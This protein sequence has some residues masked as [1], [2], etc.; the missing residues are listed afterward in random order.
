MSYCV[1]CGVELDVTRGSCPLCHTKVY[2]PNQPVDKVSPTPYPKNVG[3]SEQVDS[4]E[5]MSLLTIILVTASV[6]CGMLNWLVFDRSRWSLYIIGI[7]VQLWVFVLPLFLRERLNAFLAIAMDGAAVGLYVGMIALFHPGQGWYPEIAL[8]IIVVGTLMLEIFYLFV[9]RMKSSAITK[10]MVL[11][12]IVAALC[13]SVQVMT[14]FHVNRQIRLT[15]SAVVLAC[16]MAIDII[17]L[18]LSHHKGARNELRKRM[19]F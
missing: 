18:A 9:I 1:N 11:F 8:P 10:L 13:V 19:H 7:F 12:G 5:L 14:G 3:I 6:V 15:W 4:R 16:C 2:N 17:L